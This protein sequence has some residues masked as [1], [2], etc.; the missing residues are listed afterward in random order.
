[1]LARNINVLNLILLGIIVSF[2]AYILPPLLNIKAT[3]SPPVPK[4]TVEEKAEKPPE[5][6]PPPSAME[7][8]I[9]AEQNL[10]NPERKIPT[11]KKDEKPLPK[12]EF[13]LYGTLIT[14][15]A[16]IAFLEDLK[17]PYTTPGRGKRQRTLRPGNTLSGYTLSE[18]HSDRVVMT[19][20]ED[21]IELLVLDSSRAKSR[22]FAGTVA[23]APGAQANGGAPA[24]QQPSG[25]FPQVQRTGRDLR[26]QRVFRP[27]A[28]QQSQTQQQPQQIQ[29]QAR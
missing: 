29:Q 24:V 19:R 15:D 12:P 2:A 8:T 14:G 3:Y 16:Q 11:E 6:A 25:T 17:A 4:K 22:E 20:G 10:F 1:M 13:V 23:A 18:I 28:P 27:Q 26:G 21:R 9:I 7:Y 5:A